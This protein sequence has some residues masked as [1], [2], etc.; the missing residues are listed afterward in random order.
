[1]KFPIAWI[2]STLL[3]A[4]ST[5]SVAAEKQKGPLG[6]GDWLEEDRAIWTDLSGSKRAEELKAWYAAGAQKNSFI[7]AAIAN[8]KAGNADAYE[9]IRARQ[10]YYDWVSLAVETDP[11]LSKGL[12]DVRFFHATAMVTSRGFLG[13]A[14]T[15]P[16]QSIVPGVKI[17]D[18]ARALIT[19]INKKLFKA[20]VGVLT[21]VLYKWNEP[22]SPLEKNA[23]AK[24]SALDFDKQMVDFEQGMV[25]SMIT[26]KGVSQ[27]A[28]DGIN[29]VL[30]RAILINPGMRRANEMAEAA[31]V[32]PADFRNMAWRKAIGLAMV[33]DFHKLSADEYVKMMTTPKA[34]ADDA[35]AKKKADDAVAAKKKADDAD[36]Q[37][38][39]TEAA[40]KNLE[41]VKQTQ[42]AQEA[43]QKARDAAAAAAALRPLPPLP[44]PPPPPPP[45]PPPKP[46]KPPE[47]PKTPPP[48]QQPIVIPGR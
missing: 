19:D 45:T 21:N 43:A 3:L 6:P 41:M 20:N 18:P 28:I 16:A 34:G 31:G 15:A 48:V 7:Q 24:V 35:A 44:P 32:K 33:Y 25:E 13:W 36:A 22:R 10:A 27:E 29:T 8:T 14:E 1:M 30:N 38:R 4:C 37:R 17:S 47:I 40:Q 12:G 26:S 11:V 39:A 23:T 9:S 42:A 2:L 5:V 46:P